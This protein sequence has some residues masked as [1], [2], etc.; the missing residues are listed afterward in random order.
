MLSA[1]SSFLPGSQPV[2]TRNTR[3]TNKSVGFISGAPFLFALPAHSPCM[4]LVVCV[5]K[6][7]IFAFQIPTSKVLMIGLR[8]YPKINL[9]FN[10]FTARG[11]SPRS[12]GDFSIERD[13]DPTSDLPSRSKD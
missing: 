6:K 1:V 3:M 2:K 12:R 5:E 7:N 10:P 4:V 8:M 11:T 13:V 9:S